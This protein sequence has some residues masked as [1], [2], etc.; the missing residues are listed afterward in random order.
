MSIFGG[1]ILLT[2]FACV[3]IGI[4]CWVLGFVQKKFQQVNS[5]Y[6][7]LKKDQRPT[8]Q[9]RSTIQNGKV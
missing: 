4:L 1:S 3:W 6:Q 8:A 2:F 9:K 7:R 5:K